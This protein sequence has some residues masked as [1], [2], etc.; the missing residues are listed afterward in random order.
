MVLELENV[1]IQEEEPQ[2]Q[3]IIKPKMIPKKQTQALIQKVRPAPR[4]DPKILESFPYPF[5][6]DAITRKIANNWNVQEWAV[7]RL[8]RRATARF[9]IKPSGELRGL[10][11]KTSSGDSQF[12]NACARAIELAD[13]FPPLPVGYTKNELAIVFDFELGS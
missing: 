11:L 7:S 10:V 4:L 6:L 8:T 13:P 3:A 1:R 2:D 12:D 9:K 5:Y